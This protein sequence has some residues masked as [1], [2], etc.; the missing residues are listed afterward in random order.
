MAQAQKQET[1]GVEGEREARA[2]AASEKAMQEHKALTPP[3]QRATLNDV[4]AIV[5]TP[6]SYGFRWRQHPL[7]TDGG[8]TQLRNADTATEITNLT[9]FRAAFGDANVQAWLNG[10]SSLKVQEDTVCR[11][12]REKDATV[13][14]QEQRENVVRRVLLGVA[15]QRG[16][17]RIVV[18][19]VVKYG[20][21][22][23][24]KMYDSLLE[25]QQVNVA[26]MIEMGLT[27]EQAKQRLGIG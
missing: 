16:G 22:L 24:G 12:L 20:P 8:S 7:A 6:E 18:R 2:A 11:K 17:V 9:T 25:V 15:A 13:S 1:R 26:A 21:A 27:I 4:A 5:K 19:E 3:V 14:E 23:D 10:A